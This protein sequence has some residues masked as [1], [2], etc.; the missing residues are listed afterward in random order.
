MIRRAEGPRMEGLMERLKGFFFGDILAVRSRMLAEGAA[1]ALILGYATFLRPT[2]FLNLRSDV[3]VGYADQIEYIRALDSTLAGGVIYKDFYWQYGPA[4]LYLQLLPYA[5]FGKN[6]NALII[7]LCYFLP[8][9][10]IGLS[11]IC[12]LAFF[13]SGFVRVLFVLVCVFHN[14]NCTLAAPRHLMA[15]IAVAA[16]AF[17]LTRSRCKKNI[18]V[19]GVLAGLG[20]LTGQEYGVAASAAISLSMVLLLFFCGD[21]G[22]LWRSIG[23]FFL[24]LI[25][26]AAPYFLYLFSH[27]VLLKYFLFSFGYIRNFGNPAGDQ[28]M[29]VLPILSW[30]GPLVFISSLWSLLI[31]RALRFYLPLVAY[32]L[33]LVYSSARFIKHRNREE[34]I[35]FS[36]CVYGFVIYGRTLTGPAYGYFAYGLVPAIILGLLAF[37][38]MWED[39][40]RELSKKLYL[41]AFTPLFIVSIT[42]IWLGATVESRDLF[43]FGD[44]LSILKRIAG[45]YDGKIYYDRVGF[46]LSKKSVEQY[47]EINAYIEQHTTPADP[48]LVYPWGPY[49]HFTGRPSPV[50]IRDT[51]DLWGGPAIM[52]EAIRQLDIEKPQYAVLNT[53]NAQGVVSIGPMRTDVDD[54]ASWGTLDSPC[55]AGKGNDLENYILGHY[56]TVKRFDYA[57]VLKRRARPA[58]FERKFVEQ[59]SL[60]A[61]PADLK[62]F[63]SGLQP[64]RQK[65]VFGVVADKAMVGY[66]F[67]K[68]ITA[69][70]VEFAFKVKTGVMMKALSKSRIILDIKSKSGILSRKVIYVDLLKFN[71][72]MNMWTGFSMGAV[73]P[74]SMVTLTVETPAPYLHPGE[75]EIENLKLL[76]EDKESLKVALRKGVD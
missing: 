2:Y 63:L 75:L 1:L 65:N 64:T 33:G 76:L 17:W 22:S 21:A 42:L 28:F 30:G 13:R 24:G 12:S 49:N 61:A 66:F 37:Q 3:A 14:V 74:V 31:S 5:L 18:F 35:I 46:S 41:K 60:A 47:R 29:P 52:A 71:R 38:K 25:S 56:S 45:G 69:S 8:F 40:I 70:H 39:S 34:V 4:F 55:F 27:G 26:M 51:Y 62:L 10:S 53:Y 32:S 6:H 50:S 20:I 68:P 57:A 44:N 19:V 11:Y 54:F 72:I 73:A 58:I 16:F 67:K 23:L 59:F 15:E 43:S 36:L 7:D 48:V 9:I